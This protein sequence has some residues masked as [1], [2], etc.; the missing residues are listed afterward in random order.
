MQASRAPYIIY[1]FAVNMPDPLINSALSRLP[2]AVRFVTTH[3][4]PITDQVNF[5]ALN[6]VDVVHHML[7]YPFR[8]ESPRK[9]P[10]KQLNIS[11]SRKLELNARRSLYN[12]LL[13]T[14]PYSHI[15]PFPGVS[16][17]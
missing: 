4:R 1:V 10:P 12:R 9:K 11:R 6:L 2:L 14:L 13:S 3:L 8:R 15:C 17:L 16:F 5:Q 7:G